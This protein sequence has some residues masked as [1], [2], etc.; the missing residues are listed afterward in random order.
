MTPTSPTPTA[1]E[2]AITA[3]SQV[4]AAVDDW[5]ADTVAVGVTDAATTLATH[6]PVDQVLPFASVTKPLS[7][8]AVLLAVQHGAVHLDEPLGERCPVPE[9]TVRHLLS[10]AGG[11]PLERGGAPLQPAG[12]RRVYSDW[13]FDLLGQLVADRVGLP[14]DEHVRLEV[15]EPLGMAS[16]KLTGSPGHAGQGSVDDLL[17]FV[18]ELLAP[19]LL[20]AQLHAAAVSAAF[21]ELDGVVPGFGRQTPCPWGLGVELKADKA[22][23][24]TG[25]RLAPSTFGHFGQ[26]GSMLWVDPTR[27]VGLA[28][29]ADL[30]F[31][32]WAR[33]AW[34][35]F[36]DAVADA[37]DA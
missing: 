28:V 8:Y 14:F 17:R 30:P 23:H 1:E 36:N 12:H 25:S 33:R 37:V 13:G 19:R 4:L 32:E 16:T 7:A 26:S 5:P 6:G 18:R 34:P 29:L 15:L 20:D 31:D 21:P 9:A 11:L 3:L 24:W 10:H 27:E 2:T 22:P 35:A